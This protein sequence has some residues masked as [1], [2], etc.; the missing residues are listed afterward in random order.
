MTIT[1]DEAM[2]AGLLDRVGKPCISR[3]IVDL[4][5]AHVLDTALDDGYPAMAADKSRLKNR[6]GALSKTDMRAVEEAILLHF[7]TPE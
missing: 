3:F 5:M 2:Y 4:V 1:R 7:V 6:L